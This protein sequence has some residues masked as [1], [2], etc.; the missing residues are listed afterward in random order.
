MSNDFKKLQEIHDVVWNFWCDKF[1][2]KVFVYAYRKEEENDYSKYF[3]TVEVFESKDHDYYKI[4]PMYF[5][6]KA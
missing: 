2:K 1:A 6:G 5:L 4:T 3:K